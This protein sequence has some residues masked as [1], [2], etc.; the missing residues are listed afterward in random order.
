MAG[1]VGGAM[2]ARWAGPRGRGSGARSGWWR[3]VGGAQWAGLWR[4]LCGVR[5]GR[6]GVTRADADPGSGVR[7]WA[8]GRAGALAAGGGGDLLFFAKSEP[9]RAAG[10]AAQ[11]ERES[12][13]EREES[14]CPRG[15][16]PRPRGPRATPG[17]GRPGGAVWAGGAV[18]A[19]RRRV[20]AA[21]DSGQSWAGPEPPPARAP[22]ARCAARARPRAVFSGAE[23]RAPSFLLRPGSAPPPRAGAGSLGSRG[24]RGGRPRVSAPP[25]APPVRRSAPRREGAG[26]DSPPRAGSAWSPRAARP[27]VPAPPACCP[28][29]PAAPSHRDRRRDRIGR[30]RSRG[31]ADRG[32]VLSS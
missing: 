18:G 25:P 6:G 19:A 7:C 21:G 5:G 13:R 31:P 16:G 4:A 32:H 1:E 24:G 22:A 23:T 12:E 26:E 29:G 11:G 8:A 9:E 15:V 20:G 17:E 28:A 2:W 14:A 27:R 3:A 10:A 30:G